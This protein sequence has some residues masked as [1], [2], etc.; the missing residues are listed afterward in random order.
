MGPKSNDKELPWRS[1]GQDSTF[2]LQGARVQF[3]VK[4]LRSHMCLGMAK[5]KSK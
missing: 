1:R 5:Y 4:E 3:L 2:S